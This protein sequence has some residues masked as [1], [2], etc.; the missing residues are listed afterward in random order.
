MLTLLCI[1]PAVCCCSFF[2][3]YVAV[4]C[5]VLQRVAVCRSNLQC[6]AECCSVFQC[7][8]VCWSALLQRG[9]VCCSVL[10][11]VAVSC[12]RTLCTYVRDIFCENGKKNS[13]NVFGGKVWLYF[14]LIDACVCKVRVTLWM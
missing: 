5:S 4:C 2:V 13:Y 3:H 8:A 6:V 11:C 7:V 10:Q 14:L 1:Q 12:L 9:V